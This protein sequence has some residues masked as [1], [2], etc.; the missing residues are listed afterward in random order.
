MSLGVTWDLDRKSG[1]LGVTHQSAFPVA[2]LSWP[3]GG[4]ASRP[5]DSVSA[6]GVGKEI[7]GGFWER[8]RGLFFFLQAPKQLTGMSMLLPRSS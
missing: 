1:S 5:P 2:T 8:W 4:L 7:R 3:G 6:P